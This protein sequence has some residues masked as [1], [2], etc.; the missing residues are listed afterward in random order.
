MRASLAFF[1]APLLV[2]AATIAYLL[3]TKASASTIAWVT[4][5]SIFVAYCGIVVFGVPSYFF[6]RTAGWTYSWLW[7]AIGFLGGVV[8]WI[9]SGIVVSTLLSGNLSLLSNS[10]DA[11]GSRWLKFNLWAAILGACVGGLFWLIARP[12]RD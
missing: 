7:V 1:V 8:T 4:V 9:V 3:L 10:F 12:D 2:P 11:A 5:P 6:L